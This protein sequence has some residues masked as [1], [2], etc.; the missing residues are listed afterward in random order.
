TSERCCSAKPSS[1][2]TARRARSAIRSKSCRV[3]ASGVLEH[4]S[5]SDFGKGARWNFPAGSNLTMS[6]LA[7]E[8]ELE[9]EESK[10]PYAFDSHPALL[11]R[12]LQAGRSIFSGN[13]SPRSC[14]IA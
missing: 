11:T 1:S 5:T 9:S 12:S 2:M 13:A 3:P 7:H 6:E 8:L 4:V 10:D 14:G